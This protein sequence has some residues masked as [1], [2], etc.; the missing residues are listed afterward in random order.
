MIGSHHVHLLFRQDVTLGHDMEG[1]QYHTLEHS[2][3]KMVVNFT[4]CESLPLPHSRYCVH[5]CMCVCV[6]IFCQDSSVGIVPRL[7]T[8]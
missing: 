2:C 6:C 7:Q 3:L 1:V 4:C 8:G 5:M